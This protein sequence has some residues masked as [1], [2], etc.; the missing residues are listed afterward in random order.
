MTWFC[1]PGTSAQM[2]LSRWH[3][4][5]PSPPSSRRNKV[6]WALPSPG[7]APCLWWTVP[8]QSQHHTGGPLLKK[9]QPLRTSA[10]DAHRWASWRRRRLVVLRRRGRTLSE[11]P[12]PAGTLHPCPGRL[13]V[14]VPS[15]VTSSPTWSDFHLGRSQQRCS[16]PAEVW[17]ASSD[18]PL[19]RLHPSAGARSP[20]AAGRQCWAVAGALGGRDRWLPCPRQALH[21]G[22]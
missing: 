2:G 16:W 5:S 12:S 6:P 9:A 20:C 13:P 11:A 18:P 15:A 4:S 8:E 17:A 1:L 10:A 7:L 21:V 3:E 14:R 19:S 22:V